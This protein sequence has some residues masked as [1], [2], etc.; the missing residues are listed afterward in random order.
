M[1][2]YGAGWGN[3]GAGR[4]CAVGGVGDVEGG[5]SRGAHPP[6][7]SNRRGFSLVT[8]EAI[9]DS[10]V[11][12]VRLIHNIKEVSI[13]NNSSNSFFHK[14]RVIFRVASTM[15]VCR[16]QPGTN[17]HGHAPGG[18]VGALHFDPGYGGGRDFSHQHGRGRDRPQG[19]NT[20]NRGV[21]THHQGGHGHI[22]GD[23]AGVQHC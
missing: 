14:T 17:G 23:R 13:L 21:S 10:R 22:Q 3:Q 2:N 11:E 19:R 5:A 1:A 12:Q 4:G 7:G 6:L 9:R 15:G 16:I 8:E 20:V 18:G